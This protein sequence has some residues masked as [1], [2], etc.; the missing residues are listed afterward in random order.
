MAD[1][2]LR[3]R[4]YAGSPCCLNYFYNIYFNVKFLLGVG[5]SNVSP[6]SD[7]FP[8]KLRDT[9]LSESSHQG[10]DIIYLI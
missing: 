1:M 8:N 5:K 7:W 10:T 2:S 9:I 3:E 4:R 6:N